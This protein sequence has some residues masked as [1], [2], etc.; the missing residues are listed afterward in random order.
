MVATAVMENISVTKAARLLKKHS[1]TAT[2]Y[3]KIL[4]HSRAVA[5]QAL[6]IVSAVKNKKIN[7]KFLL[8]AALLHDIGRFK[9]PPPSKKNAVWHGV[10]GG[11]I[12]RKE[13]LPKHALVAER[14]VGSGITKTEAKKLGLPLRSYMPKSIEEKIICYADSLT[15]GAKQ[16]TLQQVL[17]RY[18]KEVGEKLVKRTLRLHREIQRMQQQ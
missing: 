15:F 2:A 5:K 13:G 14:H 4:R 11:I 9:C 3:K 18:K 10:A 16:E 17:K 12:L 7:K 1:T 8:T 6:K